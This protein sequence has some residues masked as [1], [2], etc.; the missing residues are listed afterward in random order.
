MQGDDAILWDIVEEHL[1]EAEFLW[2]T[3]ERG[4]DAANLTAHELAAGPE[5]RLA[6]H[7]DGLVLA[8][9]AVV[10]RLLVPALRDYQRDRAA[11]AGWAWLC[12]GERSALPRLCGEFL[13]QCDPPER[14]GIV[15][16]LSL[17]EQVETAHL[18]PALADPD[19]AVRAAALTIL[20][21]HGLSPGPALAEL[22]G[23]RDPATTSSAAVSTTRP[24][25]RSSSR[26]RRPTACSATK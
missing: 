4:L 17:W 22:A 18:E 10:D 24:A 15:R 11:A 20:A 1:D 25:G 14:R 21:A 9:P 3:W 5:R 19:P 7:I 6:A 12:T 16:A 13:K 23:S 26:S 8:A 2:S